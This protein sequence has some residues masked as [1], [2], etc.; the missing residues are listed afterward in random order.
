MPAVASAGPRL[1]RSQSRCSPGDHQHARVPARLEERLVL[2]RQVV[3]LHARR[4]V[5][6]DEPHEVIGE[7]LPGIRPQAAADHR[8]GRLHPGGRAPRRRHDRDV[9]IELLGAQEQRDDVRLVMRDAELGQVRIARPGWDVVVGVVAGDAE[10]G[11]AHRLPDHAQAD[12]AVTTEEL[13]H[14]RLALVSRQAACRR[15]RRTSR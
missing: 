3:D 15:A 5:G 12:A 11:G 10:V 9:W 7:R 8:V 2:R 4:L 6:L 1:S 13:A 14:E